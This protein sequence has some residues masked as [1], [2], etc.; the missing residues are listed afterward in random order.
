MK[1]FSMPIYLFTSVSSPENLTR[2]TIFHE[3]M[4]SKL[5]KTDMQIDVWRLTD[6]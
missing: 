5:Q 4:F 6:L 1:K 3:N 2:A